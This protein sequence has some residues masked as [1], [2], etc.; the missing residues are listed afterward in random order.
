MVY[1]YLLTFCLYTS[2]T[3]YFIYRFQ[4][5]SVEDFILLLF[6]IFASKAVFERTYFWA[7]IWL[8]KVFGVHNVECCSQDM[9]VFLYTKVSVLPLGQYADTCH[10]HI[11]RVFDAF[12][13]SL[14][15]QN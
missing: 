2:R 7:A 4:C 12:V 15:L 3:F 14:Q 5:S 6:I 13:F 1:A 10:W 8:N 9:P 11:Y